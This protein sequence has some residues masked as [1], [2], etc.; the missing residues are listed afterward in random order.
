LYILGLVKTEKKESNRNEQQRLERGRKKGDMS[1][2]PRRIDKTLGIISDNHLEIF[3]FLSNYRGFKEALPKNYLID[4]LKQVAEELQ[5]LLDTTVI[6]F[7]KYWIT[8]RYY[9]AIT[10]YFGGLERISPFLYL[11]NIDAEIPTK[12]K[13]YR[14]QML[15]DM[16][17]YL[18]REML[19]RKQALE[20]YS[21]DQ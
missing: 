13:E 18:T 20:R 21:A 15:N 9:A 2:D 8:R 19:N 12:L 16:L 1:Y 7:L 3:P 14:I 6:S 17:N 10:D 4:V 5:Y 11:K